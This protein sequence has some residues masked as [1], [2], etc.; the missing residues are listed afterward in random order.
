MIFYFHKLVMNMKVIS[1][2]EYL[3]ATDCYSGWC[4]ECQEFTRDE[5][6]PDAENYLCPQCE[7]NSVVGAENALIMGL[8]E[9]K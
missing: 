2:E 6:E 4:T 5:T 7:T 9:I 1:E 8:I 3:E